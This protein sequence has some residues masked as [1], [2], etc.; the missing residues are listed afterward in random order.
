MADSAHM[1]SYRTDPTVKPPFS[2]ATLIAQA[3]RAGPDKKMTLNGIYTFI[4]DHYPFYRYSGDNGWQN[5]IR[6]NLSLNKCFQKVPR[7]ANEP[8]KGAFWT[9][10]PSAGV[11]MRPDQARPDQAAAIG[12][13]AY[14]DATRGPL[15]RGSSRTGRT[16]G[17]RAGRRRRRRRR[18][19]RRT[20]PP[21]PQCPRNRAPRYTC[22]RHIRGSRHAHGYC[23]DDDGLA[24][25]HHDAYVHVQARKR[26][27]TPG[28]DSPSMSP[29]PN[30]SGV[31]YIITDQTPLYYDEGHSS[32]RL[33]ADEEF[34]MPNPDPPMPSGDAG[35]QGGDRSV[36]P[37]DDDGTYGQ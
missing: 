28:M 32:K 7:E 35:Y 36:T 17:G 37:L 15:Q 34:D 5:S 19:R 33:R 6:H 13:N 22:H 12:I 31:S 4:M 3:I 21:R 1:P 10:D 30:T 11:L 27:K 8:G 16:S 25:P 14:P 2:Y 26:V 24:S 23:D 20:H 9:I 29:I 18:Q